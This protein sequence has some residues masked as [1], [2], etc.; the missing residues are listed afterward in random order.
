[1]F[2]CEQEREKLKQEFESDKTLNDKEECEQIL[3]AIKQATT[4][5][6]AVRT[7]PVEPDHT[8]KD[9]PVRF[10]RIIILTK[11][12][13]LSVSFNNYTFN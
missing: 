2:L 6:V 4:D 7:L 13:G 11:Q 12:T 1:M 5:P 10:V 9:K 8:T 3:E